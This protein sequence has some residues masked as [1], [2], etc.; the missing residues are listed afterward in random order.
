MTTTVFSIAALFAVGLLVTGGVAQAASIAVPNPSFEAD[1]PAGVTIYDFANAP[2][3]S[4]GEQ[5]AVGDRS[6]G[7][8]SVPGWNANFSGVWNPQAAKFPGGAADGDNAAYLQ[9]I[10]GGGSTFINF[11]PTDLV[12]KAGAQLQ[13]SLETGRPLSGAETEL[14]V[15]IQKLGGGFEVLDDVFLDLDQTP[16]T[17]KPETFA[18]QMPGVLPGGVVEGDPLI[19]AIFQSTAGAFQL[20]FVDNISIQTVPEPSTFALLGLGALGLCVLG[21]RRRK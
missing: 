2:R 13:V 1:I 9:N 16:G 4:G 11:L 6:W 21:R 17:W 8:G 12:A 10:P 7:I 19:F 18:L 5:L 14:R 20:S 15:L 3:V